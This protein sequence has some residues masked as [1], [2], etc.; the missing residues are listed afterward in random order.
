MAG[1]AQPFVHIQRL[2]SKQQAN[3]A[4]PLMDELETFNAPAGWKLP[5]FDGDPGGE[6]TPTDKNLVPE[7]V[8]TADEMTNIM[9]KAIAK[10]H[11]SSAASGPRATGSGG[12]P[13]P[14]PRG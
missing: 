13:S 5:E 1:H 10:A 14:R 7:G 4:I 3:D 2:H 11:E 6:A 8:S 12:T 9:Q